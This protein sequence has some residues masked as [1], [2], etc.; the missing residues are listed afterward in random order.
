MQQLRFEYV[1]TERK[2]I[3]TQVQFFKMAAERIKKI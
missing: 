3:S 2:F 1:E